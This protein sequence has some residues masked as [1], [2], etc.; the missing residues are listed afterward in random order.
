MGKFDM[1]ALA[2]TVYGLID[3]DERGTFWLEYTHPLPCARVYV[4]L[5][6]RRVAYSMSQNKVE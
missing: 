5:L 2:Y 1:F 3:F 6:A 4:V